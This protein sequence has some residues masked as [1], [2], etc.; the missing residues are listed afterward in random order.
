MRSCQCSLAVERLLRKQ[1][2]VGSIPIVGFYLRVF[3]R[4]VGSAFV[5]E[6]SRQKEATSF[7][8]LVVM[9]PA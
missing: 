8:G 4:L 3:C 7:S 6:V 2:V 1:K 5:P 9:T